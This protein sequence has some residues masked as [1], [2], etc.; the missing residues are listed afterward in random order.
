MFLASSKR[1]FRAYPKTI[2]SGV[3]WSEKTLSE[4]LSI[5]IF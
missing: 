3:Y 5:D 2:I 1:T 4:S